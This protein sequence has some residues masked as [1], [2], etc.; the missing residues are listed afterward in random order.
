MHKNMDQ[1]RAEAAYR[2]VG[3][4]RG[5]QDVLRLCVKMPAMLQANGLLAS[6][7]FLLAKRAKPGKSKNAHDRC[8]A[9]LHA[10]LSDE[11]LGLTVG[12]TDP[13]ETFLGWVNGDGLGS[14]DLRRAT[15]ETIQFAVWLKRAA[16][17]YGAEGG[18]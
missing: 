14:R 2:D 15:A 17:A 10:F 12:S 5:D 1:I 7:A 13:H 16:E 3:E 4:C 9:I 11:R 8:L 18:D 6:W